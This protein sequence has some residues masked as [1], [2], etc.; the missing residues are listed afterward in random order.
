MRCSRRHVALALAIAVCSFVFTGSALAAAPTLIGKFD[1]G[2]T[3]DFNSPGPIFAENTVD[4]GEYVWTSDNVPGNAWLP[5]WLPGTPADDPPRII[6]GTAPAGNIGRVG[7]IG[8]QNIT[9]ADPWLYITD[10]SNNRL[11]AY[12]RIL[13]STGNPPVVYATVRETT[14]GLNFPQG[15]DFGQ[16][17]AAMAVYV[18]NTNGGN[19][20]MFDTTNADASLGDFT[21]ID[22]S[23]EGRSPVDV[24]VDRGTGSNAVYVVS[25]PDGHISRFIA[26][27]DDFPEYELDTGSDNIGSISIDQNR[28][29]LYGLTAAGKVDVWSL[30]NDR[31]LGSFLLSDIDSEFANIGTNSRAI[32]IDP[33]RDQLYVSASI[34]GSF[35]VNKFFALSGPDCVAP[36]PRTVAPGQTIDITPNC[37]ATPGTQQFTVTAAPAKGTANTF[38]DPDLLSYTASPTGSGADSVTYT[39]KSRYGSKAFTQPITIASSAPTPAQTPTYRAD[40][41]LSK[42]TGTILVKLPGTN[43]FVPLEKDAVV[44]LGTIVDARDGVAVVTWARPDGT[45]YSGKFWAGVFQIQQTTDKD[46][47]GV[48]KLRDDQI[49]SASVARATTAAGIAS[50]KTQFDAY[51]AKKKGKR[52]NRVWGDAKGKYRTDGSSS[53]ASVRGTIWLVENYAGG[54]R[55]YVKQGVVEVKDFKK[56]KKKIKLKKG[57]QY[58]AWK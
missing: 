27:G 12:H 38:E 49:K 53:S 31:Y 11:L 57:Q 41:N 14:A 24:Q 3:S 44:P 36:A 37:G 6:Q 21:N 33:V 18:A 26:G 16:V 7:G 43:T 15:L 22:W 47:L 9:T 13:G 40:A 32:N 20:E 55:T 46:P 30:P 5:A 25:T 48:V 23:D 8:L 17:G 58:F 39:V 54:T 29:L 50:A 42:S 45:T 52:K 19:I 1:T 56:K 2:G 4:G 28:G 51:I 10:S 35:A 34:G